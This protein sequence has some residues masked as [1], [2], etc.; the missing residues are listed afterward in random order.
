MAFGKGLLAEYHRIPRLAAAENFHF[1]PCQVK[2]IGP[3]GQPGVFL[4][5]GHLQNGHRE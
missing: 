1:A 3:T 5:K 2:L 4:S